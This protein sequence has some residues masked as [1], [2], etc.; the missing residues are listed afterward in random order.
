[1]SGR[2]KRSTSGAKSADPRVNEARWKV[3]EGLLKL[4][5]NRICADCGARGPRWASTMFG[6]FIC[7]KCSGMHRSMGTHVSR[8]K[9]VSQDFWSEDEVDKMVDTGNSLNE[10]LEAKCR[11]RDKIRQG[12]T[13]S[14]REY[15][16]RQKYEHL[17][18][19]ESGWLP[20]H[21]ESKLK[22]R[23]YDAADRHRSQRH[24]QRNGSNDR[25][26]HRT[27]QHAPPEND[28]RR[29][30]SRS[31]NRRREQQQQPQVAHHQQQQQQQQSPSLIDPNALG[32]PTPGTPTFFKQQPVN[33]L[34]GAPIQQQQQ[35]AAQQN[36]QQQ[37]VVQQQQPSVQQQ[38]QPVQ[39]QG[40]SKV[41]IMSLYSTSTPQQQQSQQAQMT[42]ALF[43]QPQLQAQQMYTPQQQQQQQQ[44][45]AQQ[46]A[47][48]QQQQQQL[49]AQQQAMMMQQQQ[50]YGQQQPMLQQQLYAQQ[51]QQP[52]MMMQQQQPQQPQQQQQQ[53]QTAAFSG[54]KW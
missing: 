54:L 7:I 46:Q 31:G 28:R 19:A 43:G 15:F 30:R 37:C 9:S 29:E 24:H 26:G 18:Y 47:L 41:D 33:L 34:G 39:Q 44:L 5:A 17:S 20:P 10:K 50:L 27:Q 38:Q 4:D 21:L 6:V 49:Y 53:P 1:M 2:R 16:I 14:E 11:S 40:L 12:C 36:G 8:V 32:A 48:L 23:R 52:M 3:L 51:Q 25:Y 42:A 22:A 35:V 45:Y 13:D